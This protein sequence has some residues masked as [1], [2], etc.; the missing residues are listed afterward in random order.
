MRHNDRILQALSADP[1]VRAVVL[2]AHY[3]F[4]AKHDAAGL[5]SGLEASI[6]GLRAAGKHVV[7][8]A[9][10]PTYEYPVPQALGMRALWNPD[11][12]ALGQLRTEHAHKYANVLNELRAMQSRVDF[13]IY[14]PADLLCVSG[15]CMTSISGRSLY[16]DSHHLS[17]VGAAYLSG[18]VAALVKSALH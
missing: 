12:A 10:V 7:V 17:M 2:A 5:L 4:Y 9:P 6:R 15:T 14:D 18:E 16:F 8:L 1:E 13:S 11:G 3:G